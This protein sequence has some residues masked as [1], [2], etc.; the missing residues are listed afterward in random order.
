ML[1]AIL[2]F[3]IFWCLVLLT[4]CMTAD[5]YSK[6]WNRAVRRP[7]VSARVMFWL[8]VPPAAL[9]LHAC[10]EVLDGIPES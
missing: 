5:A 4:L 3:I 9:V 8:L 7:K 10:F 1:G 6:V 2:G